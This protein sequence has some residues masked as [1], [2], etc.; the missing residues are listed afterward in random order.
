M[1]MATRTSYKKLFSNITQ[2][3]EPVGIFNAV[4]YRIEHY[5]AVQARVYLAVHISFI[6]VAIIGFVPAIQYMTTESTNSGFMQ[7]VSLII[8][9]GS[10]VLNNWK[11]FSLLIAESLPLIGSIACVGALFICVNSIFRGIKY[12]PKISIKTFA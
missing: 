8:S 7:Y 4:T 9:D 6:T 3:Q 10:L 2:E 5:R 1:T 12:V 11:E